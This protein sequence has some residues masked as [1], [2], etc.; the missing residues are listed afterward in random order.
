[1]K[2]TLPPE[3]MIPP[4]RRL[5]LRWP[6]YLLVALWLAVSAT[7]A[8]AIVATPWRNARLEAAIVSR[9][10]AASGRVVGKT[11][12]TGMTRRRAVSHFRVDYQFSPPD[13]VQPTTATDW[14]SGACFNELA[15]GGPLNVVYDAADPNISA[16]SYP[17]R[18]EFHASDT[19]LVKALAGAALVDC[20]PLILLIGWSGSL[21]RQWRAMKYGAV[22]RGRIISASRQRGKT[23][24]GA[25]LIYRFDFGAGGE[26][27]GSALLSAK[28]LEGPELPDPYV[29]A[30]WRNTLILYDPD[31]PTFNELYRRFDMFAI[32]S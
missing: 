32:C 25:L 29:A 23:T 19:P 4:P 12:E 30:I 10:V 27:E 21:R 26:V 16:I 5:R 2:T 13:A 11:I 9:G 22:G 24:S 18:T 8:M 1:M 31:D 17:G 28:Y 7:I 20:L 14:V 6:G 3:L 15:E